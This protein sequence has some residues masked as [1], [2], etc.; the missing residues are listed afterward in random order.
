MNKKVLKSVFSYLQVHLFA[1]ICSAL[2]VIYLVLTDPYFYNLDFKTHGFNEK[3]E[4]FL[5]MTFTIPIILTI[6]F[7]AYRIIKSNQKSDK[8]ILAIVSIV[9]IFTFIYL[10]K[11]IKKALFFFDNILL[12]M[13]VITAIYIILFSLVF[14]QEKKIKE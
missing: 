13:V 6:L 4:H 9:G 12:S 8:S 10:D 2:L 14:R 11:F 7:C 1:G 3:Y 5:L